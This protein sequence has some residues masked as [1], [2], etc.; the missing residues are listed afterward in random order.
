MSIELQQVTEQCAQ[1]IFVIINLWYKDKQD[2][3]LKK[4]YQQTK[5]FQK[6]SQLRAIIMWTE[7]KIN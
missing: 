4:I 7:Q 1:K 3:F 2:K 5:V 6:I